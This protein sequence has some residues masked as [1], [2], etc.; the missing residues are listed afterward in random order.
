MQRNGITQREIVKEDYFYP[1]FHIAI[2][3]IQIMATKIL[4][5]KRALWIQYIKCSSLYYKRYWFENSAC[6][7]VRVCVGVVNS[8][9]CRM[10]RWNRKSPSG[11]IERPQ[12]RK[13]IHFL[14]ILCLLKLPLA[15]RFARFHTHKT[16]QML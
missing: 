9:V 11:I 7:C 12:K 10:Q 8:L 5:N 2:E 15:V 13:S 16:N 4:Y 3:C 14:W 6:V 1:H